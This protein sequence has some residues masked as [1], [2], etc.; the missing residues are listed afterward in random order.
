[1]ERDFGR[2]GSLFDG[3][4][5]RIYLIGGEPLLHPDISDCMQIARR[6][7]PKGVISIFTNGL[8][9]KKMDG[10]FW[11]TCRENNIGIIV[12][13]YPI[14][15]DYE[16]LE[17]LVRNH[18]V[19]FE[20]FGNSKDFKYMSNIGLDIEGKQNVEESFNHCAEANNCIKLRDG[21]LFTCTRPAAIYKFNRYFGTNLEV[22]PM[23]YIDIY[24]ASSG[25][26]ILDFLSNPI[27]F[28]RYCNTI[29]HRVAREWAHSDKSIEEWS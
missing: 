5:E 23:D 16:A 2:L 8:L 29:N 11:E 3:E 18:G 13:R 7:F 9:L 1:M 26:E 24:K 27:P 22:S 19:E 17:S 4:A 6:Y 15:M 12:T 28:C 21:K 14:N 10:Q 25:E 20:L